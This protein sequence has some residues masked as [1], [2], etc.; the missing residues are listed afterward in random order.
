M[1]DHMRGEEAAGDPVERIGEENGEQGEGRDGGGGAGAV[2]HAAEAGGAVEAE[3]TDGV[4]RGDEG[5]G[6]GPR[7]GDPRFLR[8]SAVWATS[9][10]GGS[11][12]D[13][14]RQSE[15]FPGGHRRQAPTRRIAAPW[16]STA[17]GDGR[18]QQRHQRNEAAGPAVGFVPA[19]SAA[20]ARQEGGR[21]RPAR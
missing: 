9:G 19:A 7:R 15:T 21:R 3:G 17:A 4:E 5:G 20:S 13:E 14:G 1:L 16:C 12:A 10:D 8:P 18:R 6:D 2:H 11:Q